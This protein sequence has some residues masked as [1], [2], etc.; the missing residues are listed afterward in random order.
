MVED[1][2]TGEIIKVF[3]KV[4][5][6]LGY[7]FLESIYHNAMM[8]ELSAS[9]R[10]VETEKA[11]AVNYNGRI[12]RTFSADLLIDGKV[13]VEL[14]AKERIAEPHEAQLVNYL[15]ATEMEV[16]LLLNFGRK[17]EFKRKYFANQPKRKP[18]ETTSPIE[19]LLGE[20][21]S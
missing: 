6:V 3:Y 2:L 4:Y 16:G 21:P 10:R 1:E 12:V 11:I 5:N 13:I 17:P 14:K 7:G 15:R 9:G 19:N 20:D 18:T 8:I